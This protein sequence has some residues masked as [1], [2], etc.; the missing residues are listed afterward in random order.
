MIRKQWTDLKEYEAK[1]NLLLPDKRFPSLIPVT[2][3]KNLD[4]LPI[5]TSPLIALNPSTNHLHDYSGLI[6]HKN[7]NFKMNGGTLLQFYLYIYLTTQI[8]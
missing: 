7:G 5:K 4:L 6:K 2:Y 8:I 1:Y 3:T